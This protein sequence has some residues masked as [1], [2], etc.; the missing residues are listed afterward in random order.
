MD[1]GELIQALGD[2][3]CG[4]NTIDAFLRLWEN[5]ESAKAQKLLSRHRKELL[6]GIH[7]EERKINCLD[8][9]IFQMN[10]K[11]GKYE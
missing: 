6:D 11:G 5:G 1:R 8:Y 2:A 7:E 10:A 3:N 4:E 9:L